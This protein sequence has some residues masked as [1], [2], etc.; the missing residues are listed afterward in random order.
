MYHNL[1]HAEN[2]ALKAFFCL[3]ESFVRY[4]KD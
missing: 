3:W 1:T 4:L 2:K